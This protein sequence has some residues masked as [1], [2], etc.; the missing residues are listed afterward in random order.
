MTVISSSYDCYGALLAR[1]MVD[2]IN[3]LLGCKYAMFN[4]VSDFKF[5]PRYVAYI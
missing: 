4:I 3:Y 1:V 5:K 2:R